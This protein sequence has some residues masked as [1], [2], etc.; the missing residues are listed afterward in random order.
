MAD[1]TY[2][3]GEWWDASFFG[4]SGH[5]VDGIKL[6]TFIPRTGFKGAPIEVDY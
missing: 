6:P 2:V 3:G 5:V 1:T 4:I